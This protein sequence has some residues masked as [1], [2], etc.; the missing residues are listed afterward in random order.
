MTRCWCWYT[1]PAHFS[2]APP[3]G[4]GARP[5]GHPPAA[6]LARPHWPAAAAPAAHWP[7]PRAPPPAAPPP[8]ISHPGR[9]KR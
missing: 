4:S 7:P 8:R 9:P 6:P 2:A 1:L 5:A 3:P